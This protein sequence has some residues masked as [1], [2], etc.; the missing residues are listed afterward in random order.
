[1]P[2]EDM[3]RKRLFISKFLLALREKWFNSHIFSISISI[4]NKK[5]KHS[6]SKYKNS[7]YSFN[8]ELDYGLAHYFAKLETTKGNM[9]KFLTD[10]LMTSL[11][12]K[13]FY[14]Y[15]DK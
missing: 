5:Y 11:I 14:K 3:P 13:L 12:K 8:D 9:N 10:F 1:M 4:S 15:D 6:G 2:T 7:F